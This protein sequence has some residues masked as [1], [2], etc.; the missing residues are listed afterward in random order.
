M[1]E[2][3]RG[4]KFEKKNTMAKLRMWWAKKVSKNGTLAETYVQLQLISL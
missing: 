4:I 2:I 3:L 1:N